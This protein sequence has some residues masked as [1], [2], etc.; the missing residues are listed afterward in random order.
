MTKREVYNACLSEFTH[1]EEY[2]FWIHGVGL[3]AHEEP[4]VGTLLPSSVNFKETI[5]FEF[6]QVLA[7]EPSWLVEDLY[8]LQETGFE[9]LCTLPQEIFVL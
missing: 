9:R 6:G 7:L 3:D 2:G 4:R 1:L 8:V 5:T